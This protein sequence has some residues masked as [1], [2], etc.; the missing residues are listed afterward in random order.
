MASQAS[1][2]HKNPRLEAV[3]EKHFIWLILLLTA[4]TYV[5]ALRFDFVYDDF[6]QIV[7]N[8]FVRAWRYIPQYFVSPVWKEMAPLKPGNYYR[9]FFLVFTRAGYA[10][11][12][13][14][15]FGWHLTALL[16]HLAVTWL[17]FEVVK[18]MTGQFTTAWLA[19]LIFGIHPIHHEVVSWPSAMTE[20]LFAAL[21]ILAFLAYLRSREGSAALW[22]AASCACYALAVLTNE[23]AVILPALVFAHAWI[24]SNPEEGAGQPDL[25]GRFRT[26]IVP[27]ALLLPIGI[28]YLLVRGRVLSGVGH[29]VASVSF[30][31]WLWTL[32]SILLFYVRNWFLPFHLAEFYDVFYQPNFSLLHVLLPVLVLAALASAV[33]YLRGSLGSKTVG[34]AVAWIL[35]P[36]L[37]ALA[38]VGF[39]PDELVH[40]RYFYVPS[41]GA[42]FLIALMIEHSVKSSQKLF[43]QPIHAI[44][45]AFV[46]TVMLSYLAGAQARHWTANYEL[47]L[48]GYQIAPLN[49]TAINKLA[50]ELIARRKLDDA[51]ELLEAGYRNHPSDFQYSLN[52]GRLF[53][54]RADYSKAESFIEQAEELNPQL[55]DSYL[56]LGEIQLKEGRAKDAQE[57]LHRAV[58]LDPY[59]SAYHTGYGIVLELNGDCTSATRQFESALALSP[60]DPFAMIQYYRCR[61]SLS[62]HAPPS[63]KPGQP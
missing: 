4:V 20:S 32:P 17:A 1:G 24:A 37:P 49:S 47:Y 8:P 40:D 7:H 61:A 21:F 10:V 5:G 34:F 22:M 62:G 52:L 26:A 13:D 11:F 6:P 35:I 55:A 27:A 9:P 46:L 31:K 25:A 2:I 53:Y 48:R 59:S 38:T 23:T 14:H 45:A 50:E 51:Q 15:A 39:R 29:P 19:A 36:L 42:A 41:I 28:A 18:K 33:W 44:G 3:A 60:G 12:S 58:D 56:V 54:R 30:M 63:T 43:G 57:S 16:M